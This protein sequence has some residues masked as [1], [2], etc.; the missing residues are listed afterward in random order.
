MAAEKPKSLFDDKHHFYNVAEFDALTSNFQP[1]MYTP[2]T[3]LNEHWYTRVNTPCEKY[4]KMVVKCAYQG[5]KKKMFTECWKEIE[6]FKE[7]M[8]KGKQ[9]AR[10]EAMQLERKRQKKFK[11]AP[12]ADIYYERRATLPQHRMT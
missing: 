6:D 1:Y 4:E 11:P 3:R 2:L 9:R 5:S 7:C 10:Y 8:H 12:E